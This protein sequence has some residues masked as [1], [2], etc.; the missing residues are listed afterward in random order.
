M[1]DDERSLFVALRLGYCYV[2]RV[3]KLP[4]CSF[5]LH[6]VIEVLSFSPG[7]YVV[8]ARPACTVAKAAD[9]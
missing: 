8:K 1:N 2:Q 6:E 3:E 7:R 5:R 9:I 4:E